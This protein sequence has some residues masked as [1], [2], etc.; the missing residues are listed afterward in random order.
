MSSVG[1]ILPSYISLLGPEHLLT[2]F[3]RGGGERTRVANAEV[4]NIL[5]LFPNTKSFPRV[6]V[7][8]VRGGETALTSPALP[9]CCSCTLPCTRPALQALSLDLPEPRL[10]HLH[11]GEVLP[12]PELVVW[13][14]RNAP[15]DETE[16]FHAIVAV[17]DP[18]T[19][20]VELPCTGWKA[21]ED[22]LV[23]LSS[24]ASCFSADSAD[25]NALLCNRI[26]YQRISLF[27]GSRNLTSRLTERRSKMLRIFRSGSNSSNHPIRHSFPG[28][29]PATFGSM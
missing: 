16:K 8:D 6:A 27:R 13:F 17:L 3:V 10:Y 22:R 15:P 23:R 4:N 14:P 25:P 9:A 21:L 26:R 1:G 29:N 12:V 20:R 18:V 5:L 7:L 19:L 24:L 11:A 28:T 2:S